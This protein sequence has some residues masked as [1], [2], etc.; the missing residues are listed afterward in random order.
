[1]SKDTKGGTK[2][3][4]AQTYKREKTEGELGWLRDRHKEMC[5]AKK[6]GGQNSPESSLEGGGKGVRGA[7]SMGVKCDNTLPVD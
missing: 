2:A 6:T 7:H 3:A 1:L 5:R 4:A